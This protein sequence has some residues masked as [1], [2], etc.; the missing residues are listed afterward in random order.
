LV[1]A[2]DQAPSPTH[3]PG[4]GDESKSYITALG[5]IEV[6]LVPDKHEVMVGEPVYLSFTVRNLSDSDLQSVQGGDYR[7]RFGRPESYAVAV[8]DQQGKALP[9]LD[10]GP[11]FGGIMGPQKIPAKG[12][13]VRR[14]FL[15]HWVKLVAAGD[16]TVTCK[17]VL[18]LSKHTS[19]TW[20]YNAKTTDISVEVTTPLKIVPTDQ[21]RMGELIEA[22]GKRM[23]ARNS[24]ASD[25]ATRSLAWIEDERVIPLFNK[26]VAT[27]NYSLR[28]AALDAL[29]KFNSDDALRG[30]K[31]GLATQASDMRAHAT[32]DA[33]AGQLADNIRHS[34]AVALSRSPH[35]EATKLLLSLWQDPYYAV[36]IDVLHALGKMDSAESL[37]LLRKM[38]T[39]TNETVRNEALRYLK[40]RTEKS[41]GADAEEPRS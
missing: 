25:E 16:Y 36:R 7:N 22:L 28:F 19:G 4:S 27:D 38:S 24:D 37:E 18:K 1:A 11:S 6:A 40:L 33:L 41:Q 3:A 30:I 32:N 2:A 10:A 15:P 23:L 5:N 26:A 9:V 34:A 31:T 39:D 21:I 13:W 14:L 8:A 35:P 12:T 29:A 17:T 20:D